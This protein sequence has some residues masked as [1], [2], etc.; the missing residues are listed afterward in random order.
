M[1]IERPTAPV[2]RSFISTEVKRE[3]QKGIIDQRSGIRQIRNLE[4]AQSKRGCLK[5][6]DP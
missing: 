6:E 4:I 3:S 1:A 5:A 2:H